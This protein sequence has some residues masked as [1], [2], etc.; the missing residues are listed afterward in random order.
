VTSH[1][2]NGSTALTGLMNTWTFNKK[3]GETKG[4]TR[5]LFNEKGL[6]ASGPVKAYSAKLAARKDLNMADFL[7]VA[8]CFLRMQTASGST[9][10]DAMLDQSVKL[11]AF[12]VSPWLYK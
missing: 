3:H 2:I 4:L 10:F 8:N 12:D 7:K 11:D 5:L 9:D 1:A 6:G